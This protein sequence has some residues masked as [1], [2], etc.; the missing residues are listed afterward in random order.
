MILKKYNTECDDLDINEMNHAWKLERTMQM[1]AYLAVLKHHK[2][3]ERM[4]YTY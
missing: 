4:K 3:L 1:T 2:W